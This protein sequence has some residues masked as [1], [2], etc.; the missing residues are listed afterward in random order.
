M[1]SHFLWHEWA[2]LATSTLHESA[3]YNL[4]QAYVDASARRQE[5]ILGSPA[6]DCGTP[7]DGTQLP[8]VCLS[9]IGR[10]VYFEDE[11]RRTPAAKLL[12]RDGGLRPILPSCRSCL[13]RPRY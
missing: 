12:T 11:G 9:C 2:L 8:V 10:Y 5:F 3:F 7:C 13:E 4:A 1:L 6:N